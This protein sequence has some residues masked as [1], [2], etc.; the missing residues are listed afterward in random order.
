[1]GRF[2]AKTE[3]PISSLPSYTQLGMVALLPHKKLSQAESDLVSV[4]G[5]NSSGIANRVKILQSY[6]AAFSAMGY[7]EFLKMDKEQGRAFV[8]NHTLIYIYHDEID[9]MGEKDEANTF[10]AVESTFQTL[11]KLIKQI[12]NFNGTN[13]L[14]VS[15]HGFLFTKSPTNESE[16]CPKPQGQI[17]KLNRRFVIG[18]S[19]TNHSC[20]HQF[21][22]QELGI[23]SPYDYLIAKSIN[24]LRTQ[25]GG[26]RYVHG[27]ATLQELTVPVIRVRKKRKQDVRDVEVEIIPLNVVSTNIVNVTLYQKE[28]VSEKIRPITFKIAFELNGEILSDVQTITFDKSDEYGENRELKIPLTFNG[29]QRKTQ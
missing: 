25:G 4:D 3:H 2:E 5:K 16:F 15:N 17:I 12:N 27:G 20:T 21:S 1:M 9:K 7:E 14:I 24:K 11:I 6:D 13:I 22:A 29:S 28:P 18:K 10:N 19:F 23:E 8:K 26:I